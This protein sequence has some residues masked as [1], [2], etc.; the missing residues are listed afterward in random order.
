MESQAE[1]EIGMNNEETVYDNLN[2]YDELAEIP[3]TENDDDV[4]ATVLSIPTLGTGGRQP[5]TLN[6]QA[7]GI[8]QYDKFTKH[9][10]MHY[11]KILPLFKD[12][13]KENFANEQIWQ[14]FAYYLARSAVKTVTVQQASP[15]G[16]KESIDGDPLVFSTCL[17]YFSNFEQAVL[18][19]TP[20]DH[21]WFNQFKEVA[22]G[23]SPKFI[24][25]I[26]DD[27]RNTMLRDLIVKGIPIAIKP[28]G[29]GPIVLCRVIRAF[30][31]LKGNYIN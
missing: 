21:P 29:I 24:K 22:K 30:I 31:D 9:S 6:G 15:S 26:R 3:I 28:R 17:Q 1:N 12:S 5:S 27:I 8:K 14:T 11:H 25:A 4:T 20:L 7:A 2:F 16:I 13:R 23:E 18:K 19:L 10:E